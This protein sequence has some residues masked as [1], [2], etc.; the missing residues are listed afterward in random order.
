MFISVLQHHAGRSLCPLWCALQLR[1]VL[2]AASRDEAMV[3]E[4]L[5][6]IGRRSPIE[7]T[8]HLFMELAE[9]MSLNGLATEMEFNCPLSQYIFADALG[10]TAIHGNRVLHQLLDRKLLTVRKGSVTSHDVDGLRML[11]GFRGGY[12]NFPS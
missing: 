11:A 2:W 4:H 1:R 9:R 6:S 8:A 5:V 12:L 7:R 3:V 10:L